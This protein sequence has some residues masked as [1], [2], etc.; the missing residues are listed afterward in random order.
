MNTRSDS[1]K[2]G[3]I[4][5][6]KAVWG[7]M[8]PSFM[9]VGR[10]TAERRRRFLD[11]ALSFGVPN[12]RHEEWKYTSLRSLLESGFQLAPTVDDRPRISA[13]VIGLVK[14]RLIEGAVPLVF[15]DGQLVG[16]FP[17]AEISN[18]S[19]IKTLRDAESDYDASW[20]DKWSPQLDSSKIF[21]RMA[22]AL[23]N[24]GALIDIPRGRQSDCSFHVMHVSTGSRRGEAFNSRLLINVGEESSVHVIEEFLQLGTD[25]E[26]TASWDN[27]LT[28]IHIAPNAHCG[29]YRVVAADGGFH[30]GGVTAKLDKSSRLDSLS[31][32]TG[33]KLTRI[34]IDVLHS[35]QH[36]ECNL[37]GLVLLNKQDHVDH[38]TSVNHAVGCTRTNQLFKGV[39]TDSGRSVF[40]G[41]IFIRKDAQQ[42]EAY[43]TCKTLLLSDQAEAN[44]K[45]QLEID[46]DDVKASHGAAIG[47]LNPDEIFYLQ[48]RC[49]GRAE[50][51]AILSRGFADDVI[52]K[53]EFK[54]ARIWLGSLVDRWFAAQVV[55]QNEA[56]NP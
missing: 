40:N 28:Q 44:A 18:I 27:A 48:S 13:E 30:T 17:G 23:A 6:L 12:T 22:L 5:S 2:F 8:E 7:V 37:N 3:S 36:S 32:V 19:F 33:S 46:A 24:S 56:K 14:A 45:P 1:T 9:S 10:Q 41:K 31:L 35:A 20:W 25:G 16:D 43:Q 15:L 11:D 47:S 26:L 51:T 55:A 4:D 38:H 54:P 50:A 39:L 49:I 29:F 34:D 21:W 53:V 52:F 42:S